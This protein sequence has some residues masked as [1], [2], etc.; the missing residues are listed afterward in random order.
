MILPIGSF[1]T[2][3]ENLLLAFLF[4]TVLVVG[5]A[6]LLDTLDTTIRD[7]EQTSRL[8]GVDV[9]GSLPSVKNI[10]TLKNVFGSPGIVL[11]K[12][13]QQ[14]QGYRTMSTYEE[15]IRTLRSSILLGDFDGR[16]R[17]ILMTSANPSEGKSTTALHLAIANAEQGKRTLLIDADLRRPSIHRKL[18]LPMERGLSNVLMG[19]M[20][21]KNA[22]IHMDQLVNLDVLF[23]GPPSHRAADLIG[24]LLSDMLDEFGKEY[25][26]IIIDAPPLLGFAEPLQMAA[27]ADGVLVVSLA[28]ETNRKAVASLLSALKRLRSNVIGIVLNGVKR[29]T[30]E[31][32]NY[33]SYYNSYRDVQPNEK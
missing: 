11:N 7:P 9:I 21:W 14:N 24:P 31:G 13:P 5:G 29:H 10:T 18:G 22:L 30:A 19:E 8:L 4:S 23:S 17:S 28:G 3:C 6:I 15:A 16:L 27:I 26:L 32:Y 2:F 12:E 20:T 1:E 33:Y 25:D